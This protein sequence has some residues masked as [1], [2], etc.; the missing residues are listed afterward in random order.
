MASGAWLLPLSLL[1]LMPSGRAQIE[2]PPVANEAVQFAVRTY[3]PQDE[4]GV[5]RLLQQTLPRWTT[6]ND[7]AA[8]WRWKHTQSPFGK[9]HV[10]VAAG[11]DDT[12]LGVVALM[13]W[14][15]R[16]GEHLLPCVRTVDMAT[17][18]AHQRQGIAS[19]FWTPSVQHLSAAKVALSFHTPNRRSVAFSQKA[20]R[21]VV[22]LQPMFSIVHP[23]RL[24]P[25][26]LRSRNAAMR[27]G[28]MRALRAEPWTVDTL[29]A[30]EGSAVDE[31]LAHSALLAGNRLQTERSAAYL[32]WRYAAH[33]TH[34]YY[35]VWVKSGSTID[36]CIIF[37]LG[38]WRGA[39]RLVIEEVLLRRSDF[40][41]VAE[42]RRELRR[43]VDADLIQCYDTAGT[44]YREL[45]GRPVLPTPRKFNF[46]VGVFA[47]ALGNMPLD[48]AHWS[49]SLGDL[50]SI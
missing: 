49:L 31:L 19:S 39:R 41:V 7:P 1:K 43:T 42:L 12:I 48:L 18:P 34:S 9:S 13:P 46:T 44:W 15:L 28:L 14:R 11:R 24:V 10:M 17:H 8:L 30:R 2:A 29:L 36:G 45:L 6:C 47:P 32:A 25:A 26:P 38:S 40:K 23:L 20:G 50:E 22:K 3:Q 4:Q 16:L 33:P 27:G 35:A 5:I 21:W 37:R